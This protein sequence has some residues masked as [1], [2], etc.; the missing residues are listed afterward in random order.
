M[1]QFPNPK[2]IGSNLSEDCSSI[3]LD[4]SRI[5]K[6]YNDALKPLKP[7][8]IGSPKAVNFFIQSIRVGF[9]VYVGIPIVAGIT[10][11]LWWAI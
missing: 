4:K 9:S 11:G 6:L 1:F 10:A 7:M 8:D 3:M 2:Y 5:Q